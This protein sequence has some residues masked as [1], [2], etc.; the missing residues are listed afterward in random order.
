MARDF[1]PPRRSNYKRNCIQ[2]VLIERTYG[3][4][5]CKAYADRLICRGAI[6]PD[7]DSPNYKIEID[8]NRTPRVTILDPKIEPKTEIHMY[9]DGSL[10]LYYPKD[11]K[12]SD[13]TEC[14]RDNHS[15]DSRVARILRDLFGYG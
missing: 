8:Y 3:Q 9:R 4:F 7:P 10:C 2:R 11:F 12:W 14:S 1:R 13:R 6:R 5:S 15:M